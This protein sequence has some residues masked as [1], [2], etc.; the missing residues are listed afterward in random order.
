[1]KYF[2]KKGR[3][4]HTIRR[5]L[6]IF[7]KR[8]CLEIIF[9]REIPT[10]FTVSTMVSTQPTQAEIAI[11]C[12]RQNRAVANLCPWYAIWR[13]DKKLISTKFQR[14]GSFI[15]K[16][17]FLCS[18]RIL[19]PTLAICS[20]YFSMVYMTPY[21]CVDVIIRGNITNLEIGPVTPRIRLYH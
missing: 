12:R 13:P 18:F 5:K 16:L 21:D 4:K 20:I 15:L 3:H 10:S 7:C 19:V 6:N 11:Q 9:A 17:K 8:A 2:G 1:M 14:R